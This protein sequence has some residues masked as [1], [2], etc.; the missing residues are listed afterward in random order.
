[1]TEPTRRPSVLDELKRRKVVRVAVVYGAVGFA[2]LQVIELV[3][4]PLGL[5][6]WTL[7]LAIVLA[8]AGLPIALVLAWA[9]ELT[10]EGVKR[11]A[12]T[13][14]AGASP[15]G[16]VPSATTATDATADPAHASSW[17]SRRAL[18]AIA[19]FLAVGLGGWWMGRSA[20]PAIGADGASIAVLPFS[21]LS[22]DDANRPFTDGLHDDLLT[23]LSKISALRVTSRTSVREYRDTEKSIPVIAN[24]LGVA[25]VLEGGV[26]RSGDRI[27]INVQLIDG[28]TDEHV[29]AE[30]YDRDLTVADIFDIQSQ[31]ATAI[32][33]A[34]R[35]ELTDEERREIAEEPTGDMEA[36][37]AYLAGLQAGYWFNGDSAARLFERAAGRDPEFAAAWAGAAR[38]WSWQARLI[39]DDASSTELRAEHRAAAERALERARSLAPDAR[40]TR[41][42]EGYVRYY[43]EWDFAAAARTFERLLA[44][45]PNDAAMYQATA[46]VYRRQ[47]RWEDVLALFREAVRLDPR[48]P[49]HRLDL[50]GTLLQMR[51]Y[52]EAE[53]VVRLALAREPGYWRLP[54]LLAE[55]V[56]A[57][58]APAAEVEALLQTAEDPAVSVMHRMSAGRTGLSDFYERVRAVPPGDWVAS[59]ERHPRL[60]MLALA[61]GDSAGAIAYADSTVANLAELDALDVSEGDPFAER[62]GPTEAH[63]LRGLA[64]AILGRRSLAVDDLRRSRALWR[65][66]EDHADDSRRAVQRAYGW[67]VLGM[68]DEFF[69]ELE[70][71]ARRPAD[72]H[73]RDLIDDPILSRFADDPRNDAL[74]DAMRN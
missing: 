8:G 6:A 29:W 68:A 71:Q 52:E 61:A 15:A 28:E 48:E 17:L 74:I 19:L 45:Y 23:Q 26:Q 12:G 7:G 14:P 54:Q 36:Y 27:R 42:A 31:I 50:S 59:G 47:G 43:V 67:A 58:G 66:G 4:E 21:D 30:T 13:A 49:D 41:L 55:I 38:A 46:L 3:A 64:R 65:I 2:V 11:T 44:E 34:L 70:P 20:A 57:T 40:E 63:A 10:P 9:F 72:L 18:G 22:A 32:T 5:P 39:V 51:R 62:R 69:A 73:A 24:E 53:R 56:S 1:M 35:A 60:A 33:D 37:E 16:A 25:A